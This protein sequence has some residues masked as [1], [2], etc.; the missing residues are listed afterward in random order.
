MTYAQFAEDEHII[1]LFPSGHKG[2]A[3]DVGAADG[4]TRS[5]TWLMEQLGWEV[6][7]VEAN[8]LYTEMLK[9]N[10]KNVWMVA[11]GSE[12]GVGEFSAFELQPGLWEAVSALKVNQQ[13]YEAHKHMLQREYKFKVPI[14]TLDSILARTEFPHLDFLSVDVEGGEEDVLKGFDIARW[15]P[16]VIEL[17]NWIE[18]DTR[19]RDILLPHGYQ[20]DRRMGVND[21]YIATNRRATV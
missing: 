9:L 4:R 16:D 2:Y 18:G 20:F 7:C 17:E 1:T 8:P 15:K 19:C 21:I 10:R 13:A 3:V 14:W 6:V 12:D 5:N 11:C